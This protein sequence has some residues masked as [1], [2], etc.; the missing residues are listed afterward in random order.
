MTQISQIQKRS[1]AARSAADRS[2]SPDKMSPR[3]VQE[4]TH[5]SGLSFGLEAGLRGRSANARCSVSRPAIRPAFNLRNLRNL[6]MN[7][8]WRFTPCACYWP[9]C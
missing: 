1:R 3:S 7:L 5:F 4:W 6:R 8:H 9:G 2:E